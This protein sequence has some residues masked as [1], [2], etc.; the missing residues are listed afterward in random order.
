MSNKTCKA[1]I[2]GLG[3][4]GGADQVSGDAL[5]QRVDGLDGTHFYAYTNHPQVEIVAGSSRDAG[6]R[7]RFEERSGAKTYSDWRDMLEKEQLDIVS[8]AT[9]TPQHAEMTIGCAEKGVGAI[10]CEKPIAA[11]LNEAARMVAACTASGSLLVI[12]HQRR[13]N[14][15]LRRLRGFIAEGGVGDLVS[16]SAQWTAGRFGNVGTHMIDALHMITSRPVEAVCAKLDLAGKPDCRGP[17]FADPGGWAMIRFEGGLMGFLNAPDYGFIEAAI[18]VFGT[19]GRV[20]IEGS[21]IR[22][23]TRDG[24]KEEWPIHDP[25]VS[26]MDRAVEEIVNTI[27]DGAIFPYDVGDAVRTHEVIVGT[28]ASHRRGGSWVDLP[29]EGEDREIAVNSG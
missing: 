5:G 7:L 11:T 20:V 13:F 18:S 29:L 15:N 24:A 6:R 19:E 8:V 1:G 2:I 21:T 12:N 4:I 27:C 3:F 16:V 23:E 25:T 9:Y 26:G 17:A 14:A 22:I 28:H 10:F